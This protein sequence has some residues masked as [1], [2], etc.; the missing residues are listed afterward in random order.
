MLQNGALK[1]LHCKPN[2]ESIDT[3]YRLSGILKQ[4]DYVTLQTFLFA[5]DHFHKLLALNIVILVENTHEHNTRIS[6]QISSF[7]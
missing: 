1:F 5:Y 3:L 6:T 2:E 7:N 4:N